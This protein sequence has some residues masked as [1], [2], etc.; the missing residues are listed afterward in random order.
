MHGFDAHTPVEETLATLDGLVRA[1]KVRYIACS[2]FAGWHLMKSLATSDRYGWARYV[3]HQV[4]YSLIGREYEWELMGLG[5]DQGVGAMVW[6]PLAGGAL[7]GKIRRGQPPP[8]ESRVGKID[9][10]PF[11]RDRLVGLV[12][13]MEEVARAV[14]KSI[15]QVALNW[16]LQRPTVANVVIGARDEAQLRQNLGALDWKLDAELVRKLDAASSVKP[17]YPAWHQQDFPQLGLA[18]PAERLRS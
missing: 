15:P 9:F 1:G 16:L 8:P 5:L 2:N 12:D 18:N 10:V 11:D 17:T 7:T 3:G 6:S 14:G 4:Y 13:V